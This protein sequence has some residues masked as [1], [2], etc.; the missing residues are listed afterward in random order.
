MVMKTTSS[1]LKILAID[2]G[3]SHVKATV[4]DKNGN[5]LSDYI[6]TDTPVPANPDNIIKA[7]KELVKDLSFDRISVGFPGY[8]RNGIVGTAPNLDDKAWRGYD[9]DKR[10]EEEFGKPARVVN[11]ADMQGLGVAS[12]KGLEMVVTL[13]TGFGTALVLDGVLLPH[14]E[15]AHHPIT[16][17]KDYDAYMGDAEM[18]KIGKKKWNLRMERV[19]QTLK[20]VFNYD[21]LY[22]GGG[23]SRWLTIK[24][25]DNMTIVSNKDGIKGGAKL[26]ADDAKPISSKK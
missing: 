1:Q 4:L 16:K 8:V 5:M 9:L 24:L 11:D 23:N 2:I 6:K 7:A 18:E 26:W 15:I 13:G 25:D 14:L 10:L 20:T 22:I 19:F 12:G 21:H 3:G 17:A